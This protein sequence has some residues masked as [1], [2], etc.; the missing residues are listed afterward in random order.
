ML[1]QNDFSDH[2]NN[3]RVKEFGIF[4]CCL[5][6]YRAIPP[7][8]PTSCYNVVLASFSRPEQYIE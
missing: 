3:D 6:V 4:C 8:C 1:N 7:S 2:R 5:S